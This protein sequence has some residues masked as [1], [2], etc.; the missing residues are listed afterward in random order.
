MSFSNI[1]KPYTPKT[2]PSKYTFNGICN[3]DTTFSAVIDGVTKV[4]KHSEFNKIIDILCK[5][6]W[7]KVVPEKSLLN[8]AYNRADT[9]VGTR[10][11]K[12]DK[13]GEYYDGY[14]EDTMFFCASTKVEDAP[15]GILIID[16]KREPLPAIAGKPVNGD[17]VNAIIDVFAYEY[18]GKR[19]ISAGLAGIQYLHKGEP[20][21]NNVPVKA[22]AF[23]EELIED[24]DNQDECF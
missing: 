23:D 18:E 17:Y 10:S 4:L 21:G 13:D 6:K 8:F 7:G 14:S 24:E 3:E 5:E 12:V 20:F 16:Q 22:Q 11:P 2:G 1:R 9:P 19:G 15:E